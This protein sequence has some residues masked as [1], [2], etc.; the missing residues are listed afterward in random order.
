MPPSVSPG[1]APA[2]APS[3]SPGGTIYSHPASLLWALLMLSSASYGLHETRLLPAL[4]GSRLINGAALTASLLSSLSLL[5]MKIYLENVRAPM[6]KE[7][8]RYE[9]HRPQTHAAMALLLLSSAAFVAALWPKYGFS[10]L[11]YAAMVGYGVLFQ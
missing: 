8:L 2:P 11:L 1:S 6:Y 4:L 5:T 9:T 3:P 10:S 7:K